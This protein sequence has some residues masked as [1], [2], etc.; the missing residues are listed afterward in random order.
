MDPVQE[1]I[2]LNT[3]VDKHLL[4]SAGNLHAEAFG[5]KVTPPMPGPGLET[6]G[7]GNSVLSSG[8]SVPLGAAAGGE[9]I[10]PLIQLMLKMPGGIG[11]AD[12]F[13]EVLFSFFQGDFHSLGNGL[14]SALFDPNSLDISGH[15]ISS[16]L[17][18]SGD[19]FTLDLSLLPDDAPILKELDSVDISGS[20]GLAN[21]KSIDKIADSSRSMEVSGQIDLKKPLYENK[22][23]DLAE[24]L[25]TNGA[26][27]SAGPEI[28]PS[29]EQCHI[30]GKPDA[31]G[32][33]LGLGSTSGLNLSNTNTNVSTS[34]LSTDPQLNVG[35]N[36]LDST[37]LQANESLLNPVSSGPE[38]EQNVGYHIS[39][40]MKPSIDLDFEQPDLNSIEVDSVSGSNLSDL[41]QTSAGSSLAVNQGST[42]ATA[43][44]QAAQTGA[45]AG[46]LK[47]KA[48]S[49]KDLNKMSALKHNNNIHVS[50]PTTS[51]ASSGSQSPIK[52][53]A[54]QKSP[55]MS[56]VSNSPLNSSQGLSIYHVKPG[57][58]LWKISESQLGDGNKWNE[59]FDLN[60]NTLGDNPQLIQAGA[61][62]KI[63]GHAGHV[64]GSGQ[65]S[66]S[67]GHAAADI[68]P[69]AKVEHHQT[70]VHHKIGHAAPKMNAI[71]Q[72]KL[73]TP[74]VKVQSP[75][76]SV[77]KANS[78]VAASLKPDLSFLKAK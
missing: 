53:I 21:I 7:I 33:N 63:P 65:D 12:S 64:Q 71:S 38:I 10:S 74:V 43:N 56:P 54:A 68:K 72:A 8:L 60:K 49:F 76:L 29:I 69:I 34:A 48:F 22:T 2:S 1:G 55:A 37:K 78:I 57:D 40:D 19:H 35:E 39:Q 61:D 4:A 75:T 44:G 16:D 41:G 62:L 31:F 67:H 14:G 77:S 28:N 51:L 45:L 3:T 30:A 17:S 36:M 13:F 58:S 15:I 59:I 70:V 25:Q 73:E 32:D 52:A 24:Q 42:L 23:V 26:L 27:E 66:L 6:A 5:L 47:A 18:S 46:G 20:S 9:T 50:K 11:L